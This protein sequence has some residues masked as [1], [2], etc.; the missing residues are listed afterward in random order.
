MKTWDKPGFSP[1]L[2]SGSPISPGLSL[3]QSWGRRAA[4]KVC[5]KKVYVPVSL[6][7]CRD[8]GVGLRVFEHPEN[9]IA[10]RV[11][12]EKPLQW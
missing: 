11:S 5:V 8:V 6:A 4:Q 9:F 1:Y 10:S 7:I 2:H 3:G 12:K